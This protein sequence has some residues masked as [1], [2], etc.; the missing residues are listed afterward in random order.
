VNGYIHV[1]FDHVLVHEYIKG[2]T[3]TYQCFLFFFISH[4]QRFMNRY[5]FLFKVW[6]QKTPVVAINVHWCEDLLKDVWMHGFKPKRIS[7]DSNTDQYTKQNQCCIPNVFHTFFR[8]TL[9]ILFAYPP[10]WLRQLLNIKRMYEW[11]WFILNIAKMDICIY[12]LQNME[13]V[14]IRCACVYW[15]HGCERILPLQI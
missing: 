9:H 14:N 1:K 15:R 8:C 7:W 5:L 6:D 2:A 11:R 12:Y 10:F 4:A 3:Y 13:K